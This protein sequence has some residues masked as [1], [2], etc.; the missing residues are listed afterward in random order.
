VNHSIYFVDPTN[1]NH[2]Q[3]IESYWGKVKLR[4]KKMKGVLGDKIPSYLNDWMW[5][6]IF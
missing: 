4:V 3:N 2:T 5:R 6:D 1:G